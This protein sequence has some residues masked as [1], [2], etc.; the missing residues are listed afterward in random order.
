MPST[1]AR[2]A[3]VLEGRSSPT[4]VGSEGFLLTECIHGLRGEDVRRLLAQSAPPG[5]R[6]VRVAQPRRTAAPKTKIASV[7]RRRH[8]VARIDELAEVLTGARSRG[9]SRRS[10]P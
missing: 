8:L 6:T 4:V 9:I 10:C 7:P 3:L 2:V 1:P 5:L